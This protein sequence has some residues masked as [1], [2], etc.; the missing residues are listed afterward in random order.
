[1][2][3]LAPSLYSADFSCLREQLD[4]LNNADMLHLDVMDGNF[5]PNIT[6]GPGLIEDI[7]SFCEL[8]FDAHLM[9]SQP[10]KYIE[11]FAAAG[12]DY[13]TFHI[14]A[15]VHSHRIIQQIK[16]LECQAGISINP[17]T[18][19]EN[20]EYLLPELDLLL[21]MTVNPGF[22]G[23]KFIPAM[24]NKISRAREMIENAD[25][26]TEV[27]VDGGIKQHNV[28]KVV[29]AGAEIIVA[30]SAILG[31]DDPARAVEGFKEKFA[32]C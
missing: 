5:V 15:A 11:K 28:E 26:G 12:S 16:D 8:P 21:I 13:I 31:K 7:R 29:K 3:K 27:A 6:F 30:G 10:G 14:E 24:L 22:G 2:T 18:S 4:Y 17:D 19:L 9:I 20:V 25:T 32:S 23:Q 1:M